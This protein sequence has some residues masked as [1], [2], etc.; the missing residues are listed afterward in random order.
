LNIWGHR[1]RGAE[2]STARRLVN[3]LID[4]LI[5]IG[6]GGQQRINI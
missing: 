5:L 2:I 6:A 4:L 3:F 1:L